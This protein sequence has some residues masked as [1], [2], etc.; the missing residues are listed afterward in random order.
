MAS[1]PG[2]RMLIDQVNND[3]F[4]M[5]IRYIGSIG[6]AAP[7]FARATAGVN[8]HRIES[9]DINRQKT[10]Q[11]AGG[12]SSHEAVVWNRNTK[13]EISISTLGWKTAACCPSP[14]GSRGVEW[15]CDLVLSN[16]RVPG[17]IQ[18]ERNHAH[19]HTHAPVVALFQC[20]NK[21]QQQCNFSVKS[22]D[23][24]K[25]IMMA[26]IFSLHGVMV[27]IYFM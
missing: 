17:K 25:S 23:Y 4:V 10:M 19:P 12:Q 20:R 15:H 24:N 14:R 1:I 13:W 21:V 27:E 26:G 11:Q 7:W 9:R 22:Q 5:V 18:A 2:Q 6:A 16:C 8:V 3:F